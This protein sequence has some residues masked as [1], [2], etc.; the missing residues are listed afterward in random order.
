MISGTITD[1][2]GRTLSGQTLEAFWHSLKNAEPFSF[3]LNCALGAEPMRQYIEVLSE[4]A[5]CYIN[6][7]PNAGL[8]NELGEYDDSSYQSIA[9]LNTLRQQR[10]QVKTEKCI[11]SSDF[12]APGSYKD[13]FGAF[14]VTAGIGVEEL[15]VDFEAKHDDH[16]RKKPF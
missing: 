12:I 1:S 7:H 14:A 11:A 8:P 5:D 9:V 10:K 4:T 15:A 6:V 2:A 3:G 13:Y 16:R